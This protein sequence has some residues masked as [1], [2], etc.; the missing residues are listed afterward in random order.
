MVSPWN[1]AAHT[2]LCW[3]ICASFAWL[4]LHWLLWEKVD[5]L[6]GIDLN[7]LRVIFLA[8]ACHSGRWWCGGAARRKLT[9]IGMG[10][11]VSAPNA[12]ECEWERKK[13]RGESW[14][15]WYSICVRVHHI[16]CIRCCWWR[17]IIDTYANGVSSAFAT[18]E[19]A[20]A[21]N[22]WDTTHK[23]L[24]IFR[25]VSLLTTWIIDAFTYPLQSWVLG[26]IGRSTHYQALCRSN[27]DDDAF[28]VEKSQQHRRTKHS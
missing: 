25:I 2:T 10:Y 3:C 21:D 19:R 17:R 11:S 1:R 16:I 7:I 4:R 23:K 14:M 18:D 6:S 24:L 5:L 28:R 26:F 8:L 15:D 27:S 9:T 13:A 12:F 22:L 20:L